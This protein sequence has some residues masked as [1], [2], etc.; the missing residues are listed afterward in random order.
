MITALC[1]DLFETLVTEYIADYQ[2][3]PSIA[4]R[5]KIEPTQFARAWEDLMPARYRGDVPDFPAA[6]RIICEQ[7]G[8]EA[9]NELIAHL[10]AERL[11]QKASHFA[12]IDSRI[13]TM[14]QALRQKGL[15]LGLISNASIEEVAAWHSTELPQLFDATIFSFQVG[16]IKPEAEIYWLACESLEVKPTTT[17]FIG[18]GGSDEL[19]G[20][21]QAGLT[22]YWATWFIDQWPIAKQTPQQRQQN[23][24][25]IRLSAPSE[26]LGLVNQLEV[27]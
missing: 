18:D 21:Q 7:L 10:N 20:A 17:L 27:D 3:S 12:Q 13:L 23:G 6:L 2:P 15:K 26:V 1:F 22:P 5:L 19:V 25:F 4:E 9:P 8:R 11:S 14:L 16:K 24:Q